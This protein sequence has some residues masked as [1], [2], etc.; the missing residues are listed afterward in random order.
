MYEA[1]IH[2]VYT[3]QTSPVLSD[4]FHYLIAC[5]PKNKFQDN[6]VE[7]IILTTNDE[8]VTCNLCLG[9]MGGK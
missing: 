9:A 3:E 1:E 4:S 6:E 2:R 7:E 5:Q 8:D